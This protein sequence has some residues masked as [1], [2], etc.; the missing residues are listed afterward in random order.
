MDMHVWQSPLR[1]LRAPMLGNL[2]MDPFETR[3]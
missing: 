3:R 2:R 1:A